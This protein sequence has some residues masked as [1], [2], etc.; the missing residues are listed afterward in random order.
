MGRPVYLDCD[1]GIDDSLAI[2][3]LMAH[4]DV[5]LV[6]VGTSFGNIDA[7]RAARNTLD[8]L[9]LGGHDHVPVAIGAEKPLSGAWNGGP[10]H[11][12]GANGVGDVELPRAGRE[13]QTD[14]S[15]ADLLV[16]MAHE[17]EGELRVLAIGPLTNL[18]RA[19]DVETALPYLVESVVVMGGAARVPGNVTPVAEANIFND[20]DA[21][22]RVLSADWPLTL[23]P[24]DVTMEH[25]IEESDR[26]TL[27]AAD[28]PLP[29]ALGQMLDVYYE[30]Y[31]ATYGRRC[32]PLH[33]PLAAAVAAVG[34]TP[35]MAPTVQVVV[36]ATDGPGRGQTI[37]DLRGERVGYPVQPTARVRLV[38]TLDAPFGP[39]LIERLTSA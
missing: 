15:A 37:C 33:D 18:A 38:L 30:F 7:H 21:A 16:R 28:E 10:A 29:R 14:E 12:H 34:A 3:Y 22:D 2:A 20:P 32:A 36:D 26:A 25:L 6:G 9:A 31:V 1:T 23:I 5:D 8:L 11:I 39:H 13:P 24:L 27:L 17:H 35:V 19:L 4:P